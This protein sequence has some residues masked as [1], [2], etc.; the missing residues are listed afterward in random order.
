M[1]L[2]DRKILSSTIHINVNPMSITKIKLFYVL[3]I[4]THGTFQIENNFMNSGLGWGGGRLMMENKTLNLPSISTFS[5]FWC[6]HQH[7]GTPAGV[8]PTGRLRRAVKSV[9]WWLTFKLNAP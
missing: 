3:V 2:H 9:L 8:Y 4:F 7:Q 1:L 5:A 6:E